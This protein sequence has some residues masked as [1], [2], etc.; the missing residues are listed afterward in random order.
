MPCRQHLGDKADMSVE[1]VF[2]PSAAGSHAGVIEV[3]DDFLLLLH[4][5]FMK[6]KEWRTMSRSVY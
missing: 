4:S 5:L 6:L 3:G 2:S 1:A